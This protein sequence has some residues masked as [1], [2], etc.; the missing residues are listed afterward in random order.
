MTNFERVQEFHRAFGQQ[1]ANVPTLADVDMESLRMRLIE[2]EMD[3]LSDALID[4]NIVEVADALTD[5]LYVVYGMADIY[6]IPI[7]ACFREVH[8][9]NMAK[10]DENGKP[11]KR[12]DGKFMKPPG[13]A[14]PDIAGVLGI[15]KETK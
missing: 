14:T 4:D 12:A 3:E 1:V 6:G 8:R 10:L 7:D 11:I 13:W 2:E 9:S 5:I 15:K